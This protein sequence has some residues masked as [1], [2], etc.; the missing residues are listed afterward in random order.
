[1]SILVRACIGS[2]SP[3]LQQQAHEGAFNMF[4]PAVV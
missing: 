3:Y 1:M 2:T 4:R